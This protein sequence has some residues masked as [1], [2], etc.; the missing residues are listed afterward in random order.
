MLLG[1]HGISVLVADTAWDIWLIMLMDSASS[2]G[3]FASNKHKGFGLGEATAGVVLIGF[4]EWALGSACGR[5]GH[6]KQPPSFGISTLGELALASELALLSDSEIQSYEWDKR[7][8]LG[9]RAAAEQC[10]EISRDQ[11]TKAGDLYKQLVLRGGFGNLGN[12]VVELFYGLFEALGRMPE[13]AGYVTVLA[14]P[15]LYAL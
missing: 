10:D 5:R 6:V 13:V 8:G 9:E 2:A 11:R 15:G 4:A 3:E 1:D 12:L 14:G 7:I